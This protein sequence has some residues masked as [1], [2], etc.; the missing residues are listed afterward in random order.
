MDDSTT[1]EDPWGILGQEEDGWFFCLR[2]LG[3]RYAF[4]AA[5]ALEVIRLGPLTR[6]PA[7]PSFLPGVFHHRG[8]VLAALDLGQ[9]IADH[10]TSLAHGSR[11][12][13]VQ[14]GAWKLA[15]LA[16]GIEGLIRI[17]EESFEPPPSLGSPAAA[18]LTRV[19]RDPKGHVS[20]LDLERLIE[21]ARLRGVRA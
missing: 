5:L 8:E 11:T 13:I 21:S 17:P 18:L 12:V 15:L 9:L 10:A 1:A 6:L 4:E 16:E 3:E 14:T 2:M 7:A 20:I 19:G